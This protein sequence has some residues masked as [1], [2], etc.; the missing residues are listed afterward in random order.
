MTPTARMSAAAVLAITA[1]LSVV[2]CG[3]SSSGEPR[4]APVTKPQAAP[5]APFTIVAR[6]SAKSLGL[7]G[8]RSMAMGPDGN[9]FIT[10]RSDHVTVVSSSGHVVRRWGGVGSA[11]GKL[12]FVSYD[13]SDPADIDARITVA[14]GGAV[15]VADSGNV[16]VDE[17]TSTGRFVRS[18]GGPGNKP[19]QFVHPFDV[20]TDSKHNLYVVDDQLGTLTKFSPGGRVVWQVGGGNSQDPDLIGHL[21]VSVIDPHGRLIMTNDD[22]GRI[23]FLD[24]NGHKV[25]AFGSR[26]KITDGAC[27]ATVDSAGNIYTVKCGVGGGAVFDRAHRVITQWSS[28]DGEQLFTSPHFGSDGLGYAVG[29]D[30]ALVVVRPMSG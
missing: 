2:G 10:D 11:P 21:H 1:A 9:L 23:V 18:F 26:E 16:R 5:K 28:V 27:D 22:E 15:Y 14:D 25:D 20:V 3:G 7:T 13:P 4:P 12:R 17:F 19:G 29:M 24:E 8:P 30:G 6:Y